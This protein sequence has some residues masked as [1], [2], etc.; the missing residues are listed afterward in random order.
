MSFR[1]A[2]MPMCEQSRPLLEM[3]ECSFLHGWHSASTGGISKQ[4]IAAILAPDHRG[5]VGMTHLFLH[6]ASGR[7]HLRMVHRT[8]TFGR[9]LPCSLTYLR[10]FWFPSLAAWG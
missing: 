5:S 4:G 3:K 10:K 2:N 9:G 7:A 1:T 8:V 6:R